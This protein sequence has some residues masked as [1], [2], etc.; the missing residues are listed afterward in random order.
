MEVNG[1]ELY[2]AAELAYKIYQGYGGVSL[3]L[4]PEKIRNKLHQLNRGLP[5]E[6]EFAALTLWSGRCKYIHKLDRDTLPNDCKYKIPDFLCFI[7]ID[8]RTVP[9]LVEVK[10]SR[11]QFRSFGKK[12]CLALQAFADKLGLPVLIAYKFTSLDP[13]WWV[14]FELKKMITPNGTG[15]VNILEVMRHDL[16]SRLL[17]NFSFQIL[18][19]AA[20]AIRISKEKVERNDSGSIVSMVGKIE[21]V[22]WETPE[23]KRCEWVSLLDVLFMLTQD[24][25]KVE[26][27]QSHVI[28]KFY[29]VGNDAAFA[30]WALPLAFSRSKYFTNDPIPWERMIREHGFSFSLADV[31]QA[32]RRAQQGGLAGPIVHIMPQEIPQFLGIEDNENF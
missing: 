29:K 18:Q 10:T 9:F 27:Y 30:Y 26:E 22:Y 4:D 25:V 23:G 2:K 1:N 7:E 16:L 24:D 3:D 15:K 5:V 31:E 32:V 14:L 20:L 11:N 21:D 12:Y 6:S 8:G 19:G 28:Q 17:G 13:P